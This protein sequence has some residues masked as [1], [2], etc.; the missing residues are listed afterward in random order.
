MRAKPCGVILGYAENEKIRGVAA[1][2]DQ[3]HALMMTSVLQPDS[4]AE[5][6]V[7]IPEFFQAWLYSIYDTLNLPRT[8][9]SLKSDQVKN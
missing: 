5:K 2:K 3:M 7:Y 9:I 4:I 1:E 6:T 8:V